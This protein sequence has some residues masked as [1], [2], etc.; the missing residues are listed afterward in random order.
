VTRIVDLGTGTGSNVRYLAPR[1]GGEQEWLLI[2]RDPDLLAEARR[3]LP[4]LRIDTRAMDLGRLEDADLFTGRHLVTASALLDLVSEDWLHVLARRCRDAGAAVLFALTY[5]GES[6]CMPAEPEDT[7][8][9]ILMNR[10][11]LTDKGF[12]PAAG[13]RAA[14][15]AARAFAAVGYKVR[16]ETTTWDLAPGQDALQRELIE[17]LAHAARE[18]SPDQTATIDGWLARRLNHV[19]RG[20]S[21]I[22]VSH[23]DLAA[24]TPTDAFRGGAR[25]S[26]GAQASR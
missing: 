15:A 9:R 14:A 10:H 1:L 5:N 22:R 21:R 26:S 23:E 24:W 8:V 13:P 11:Q 18:I 20:V 12:G 17:G 25:A 19:A 4:D 16:R 6:R 7:T 3:Q 2:D